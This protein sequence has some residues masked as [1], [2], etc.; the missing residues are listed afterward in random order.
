MYIFTV[1]QIGDACLGQAWAF[2]FSLIYS[3][4]FLLHI[5]VGILISTWLS[6]EMKQS[7]KMI[8]L[9][10]W[11]EVVFNQHRLESEVHL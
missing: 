1:P 9:S 6:W 10:Y 5:A 3:G 8:E 7:K 2:I 11:K 4:E